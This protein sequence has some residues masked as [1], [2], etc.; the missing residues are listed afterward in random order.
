MGRTG[1]KKDG[2]VEVLLAKGREEGNWASALGAY[3]DVQQSIVRG[4]DL[5]LYGDVKRLIPEDVQP[6][7][8]EMVMEI[9]PYE[10][11][12]RKRSTSGPKSK[13]TALKFDEGKGKAI[14]KRGRQS[15]EEEGEGIKSPQKKRQR[16]FVDSDSDSGG[17]KPEPKT[18]TSVSKRAGSSSKPVSERMKSRPAVTQTGFLSARALVKN[19]NG[20]DEE[21]DVETKLAKSGAKTGR[22]SPLKSVPRSKKWESSVIKTKTSS[23]KSMNW[24]L[25]SDSESEIKP[26]AAKGKRQAPVID[27]EDSD[28]SDIEIIEDVAS[29]S[30]RPFLVSVIP[31]KGLPNSPDSSFPNLPSRRRV[32][33]P[34]ANTSPN[35]IQDPPS[36]VL[37]RLRRG[38]G[39]DRGFMPPPT[40]M[41][42]STWNKNAPAIDSERPNGMRPTKRSILDRNEFL[43][44]EA[45]HSGDEVEAGSSDPE[46]E[47]NSSDREFVVDTSATQAPSDYDQ[48]AIYRQGLFTQAPMDDAPRFQT[49]PIRT[50][51]LGRGRISTPAVSDAASSSP[52]KDD[53]LDRYSYGSFVVEDGDDVL[54]EGSSEP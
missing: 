37:Q 18:K 50:G 29:S 2:K 42:A 39:V 7:C 11:E 17:P 16:K 12:E 34:I 6:Q 41:V 21:L 49:G 54:I 36:P 44:I 1:R 20:S 10:R 33:P 27:F 52:F 40:A 13:Q 22:A 28:G 5:E 24:L 3:K 15:E 9:I 38:G 26:V 51:F 4:T 53:E 35:H 14:K 48:S 8:V 25:D 43:E 23:T 45:I 30:K 47:A 31:L 32:C 46:G 19:L